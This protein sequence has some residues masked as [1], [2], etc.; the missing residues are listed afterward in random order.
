[1]GIDH[2]ER[3]ILNDALDEK[4]D[5]SATAAHVEERGGMGNGERGMRG[6]VAGDHFRKCET[7]L[8]ETPVAEAPRVTR[9]HKP[10]SARNARWPL[11]AEIAHA[12]RIVADFREKLVPVALLADELELEFR[13]LKTMN[14]LK[15]IKRK[16]ARHEFR[17]RLE[18]YK[19][20][21]PFGQM[22]RTDGADMMRLLDGVAMV[23]IE[24]M[25]ENVTVD[26]LRGKLLTVLAALKEIGGLVSY[27]E[28]FHDAY[29]SAARLRRSSVF[30]RPRS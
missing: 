21:R 14:L 28:R 29:F 23:D 27:E 3:N 7:A 11:R 5:K 20:P 1:M 22:R 6:E 25:A 8:V 19:I 9:E 16:L 30:S 13:G 26:P 17:T 2:D 18:F 12:V 15:H 4:A 24:R 10:F